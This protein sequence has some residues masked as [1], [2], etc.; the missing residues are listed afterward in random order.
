MRLF[1]G[2]SNV[3]SFVALPSSI[4]HMVAQFICGTA[5]RLVQSATTGDCLTLKYEWREVLLFIAAIQWSVCAP[6]HQTD[7]VRLE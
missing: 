7:R 6:L 3:D 2:R 1:V 5:G 4:D